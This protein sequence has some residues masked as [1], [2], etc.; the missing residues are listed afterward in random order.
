MPS[1]TLGVYTFA[2]AL[3]TQIEAVTGVDFVQGHKDFNFV[4]KV[5]TRKQNVPAGVMTLITQGTN[6]FSVGSTAEKSL[7]VWIVG[8]PT[9]NG[10]VEYTIVPGFDVDGE[11]VGVD[12]CYIHLDAVI[13][14]FVQVNL[15]NE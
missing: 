9:H 12:F 3:D 8:N 7:A 5:G 15:D 1:H 13:L 2:I 10:G 6:M 4:G 11:T 14:I